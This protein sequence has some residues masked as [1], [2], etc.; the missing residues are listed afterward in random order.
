MSSGILLATHPLNEGCIQRGDVFL[1]ATDHSLHTVDDNLLS[2]NRDGHQSRRA[3]TVN[4][5]PGDSISETGP[6]RSQATEV[7]ARSSGGQGGPQHDIFN[8][9]RGHAGTLDRSANSVAGERGRFDIVEYT[10]E[11]TADRCPGRRNNQGVG[12]KLNFS[13]CSMFRGSIMHQKCLSDG[14][15]IE[16]Q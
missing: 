1:A 12:H 10:A 16:S 15:Q 4:G 9:I 6:E 5:L 13:E 11:R 2:G 14:S 8:L 3:L 7:H